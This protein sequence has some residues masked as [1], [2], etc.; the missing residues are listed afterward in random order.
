[1]LLEMV[2]MLCQNL[3]AEK[4]RKCTEFLR[5]KTNGTW[6]QLIRSCAFLLD[7]GVPDF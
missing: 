1:M 6:L 5:L 4:H 2:L 7:S 3:A